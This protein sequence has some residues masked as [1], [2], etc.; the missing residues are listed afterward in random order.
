MTQFELTI[1]FA[2]SIITGLL[3]GVFMIAWQ[4]HSVMCDILFELKKIE[5]Y[6]EERTLKKGAS[7]AKE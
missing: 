7:D 4:I 3:A 5:Q 6:Y 2:L 1:T